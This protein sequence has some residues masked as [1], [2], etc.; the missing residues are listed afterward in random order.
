MV[1]SWMGDHCL[2]C[3]QPTLRLLWSQILSR[4]YKTPSYETADSLCVYGCKKITNACPCQR[5][6]V[7]H[8][9]VLWIMETPKQQ[10]MNWKR[11]NLQK[12]EAG[13]NIEGEVPAGYNPAWL[14]L[15]PPCCICILTRLDH[16]LDQTWKMNRKFAII[17]APDTPPVFQDCYK[18]RA[19]RDVNFQNNIRCC[20]VQCKLF[21]ALEQSRAS[22][23]G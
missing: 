14:S 16:H 7:V 3:S 6:L 1:A 21:S 8:I 12:V 15:G 17:C 13:H 20:V 2:L 10:S 22:E 11:Q 4:L 23:H 9:R 5:G 19:S 18:S